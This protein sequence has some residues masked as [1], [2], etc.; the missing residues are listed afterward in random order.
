[1]NNSGSDI[2]QQDKLNIVLKEY[3][4]LRNEIIKCSDRQLQLFYIL[5]IILSAAYGL[6]IIHGISD[7]LCVLPILILPFIFRYLWEQ[8]DVEI[9]S[10]YM[11]EEIEEKRIP[12]I[13]GYRCI[14]SPNNYDKYWIGWQHY[15]DDIESQQIKK[16]S[17]NY[18]H[19]ALILIVVIS[20]LPSIIFSV[21]SIIKLFLAFPVI[22][23]IPSYQTALYILTLLLYTPLFVILIRKIR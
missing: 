17:F 8:H 12:S 9:I 16:L 10:K 1:M 18:K 20:F 3:E 6:V 4:A 22:I 15:W 13:V 14:E 23:W 2:S 5:I 21:L 7:F 11:K 19:S